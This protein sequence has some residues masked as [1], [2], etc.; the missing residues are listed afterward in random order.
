MCEPFCRQIRSPPLALGSSRLAGSP[1]GGAAAGAGDGTGGDAQGCGFVS[2]LA[3][4]MAVLV[5]RD[6]DNED[7]DKGSA[8]IQD[9]PI[10]LWN[11]DGPLRYDDT[12]W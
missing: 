8:R 5:G 1:W 11:V 2:S 7:D 6:D 12:W 3:S 4:I 9:G 10:V